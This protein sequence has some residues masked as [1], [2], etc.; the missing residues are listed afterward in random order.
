MPIGSG[1]ESL[2][3]CVSKIL[4]RAE[5]V[6]SEAAA[7]PPHD[8]VHLGSPDCE[9]ERKQRS[10]RRA[11]ENRRAERVIRLDRF[12]EAGQQADRLLDITQVAGLDGRVHVAH[13]H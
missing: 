1:D 6:L 4:R 2:W 10:A 12:D 7:L 5:P 11:S 3:W 13:R 9:H 8:R